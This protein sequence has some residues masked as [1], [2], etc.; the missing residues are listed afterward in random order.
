MNF[1][2]PVNFDK[3]GYNVVIFAL[4]ISLSNRLESLEISGKQRTDRNGLRRYNKS[5]NEHL[6]CNPYSI[7]V[8]QANLKN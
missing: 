5:G 8:R 3:R 2:V 6:C 7:A 4:S 1:F